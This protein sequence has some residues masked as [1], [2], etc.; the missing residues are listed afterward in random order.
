MPHVVIMTII[1]FFI[2]IFS[3]SNTGVS[4]RNSV[5]DLEINLYF[6]IDIIAIVCMILNILNGKD[7]TS[8]AREYA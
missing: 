5:F 7:V 3:C 2:F 1:H 8:T 4:L 6:N